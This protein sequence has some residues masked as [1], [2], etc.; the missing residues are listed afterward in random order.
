MF[1]GLNVRLRLSLARIVLSENEIH[2]LA[3]KRIG[4]H[5]RFPTYKR[6]RL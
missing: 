3:L 2:D 4:Y 1:L 6:T 5:C